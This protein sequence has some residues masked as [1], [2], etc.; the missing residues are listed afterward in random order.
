[1][2]HIYKILVFPFVVFSILNL[3]SCDGSSDQYGG[4]NPKSGYVAL[5]ILEDVRLV[6]ENV[7]SLSIPIFL[8]TSINTLGVDVSYTVT[9]VSG[10]LP[11]GFEDKTNG[12]VTILS[13]TDTGTIELALP[14]ASNGYTF[15][16]TLV[17]VSDSDFSI[18]ISDNSKITSLEVF[19]ANS[20]D[21]N[22]TI[23]ENPDEDFIITKVAS[24][25]PNN[26]FFSLTG[27]SIDGAFDI[28]STTGE[29]FVS[30][31]FIFDWET[32]PLI[33]ATIKIESG[34]TNI[35]KKVIVNLNNIDI[36]W[37]GAMTTFNYE[38]NDDATLPKNQD[39]LSS[40]VWITRGPRF[41]IYNIALENQFSF[42]YP[43]SQS[44]LGTSWA[45]G[46]LSDGIENLDFGTF[47]Q[48]IGSAYAY[49]NNRGNAPLVLY[50]KNDDI[51]LDLTWIDWHRGNGNDGG[52]GGFSYMRSTP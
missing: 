16:V 8:N 40:N 19:V 50:L 43:T 41:P 6:T 27:E 3:N 42:P 47:A 24:N 15:K 2:K 32:N 31:P 14:G 4:N 21:I 51:Y 1:M 49:I 10:S 36:F 37:T 23:D 18:G 38:G 11:S 13:G 30:N 39:R 46:S 20:D 33:E 28:N 48:I 12:L 44:P 26:T 34:S 22:V 45:V 52:V 17:G 9:E 7:E 29:L 35:T 25:F 5:D